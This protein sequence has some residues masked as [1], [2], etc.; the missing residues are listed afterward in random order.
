M[1]DEH[2]TRTG[3][4]AQ[5]G[6]FG[7]PI[8]ILGTSVVTIFDDTVSAE[9]GSADSTGIR[10]KR[11][12]VL[13]DADLTGR[14]H[15]IGVLIEGPQLV[16]DEFLVGVIPN[17]DSTAGLVEDDL[18]STDDSLE[19]SLGGIVGSGRSNSLGG[20]LS[21]SGNTCR[22]EQGGRELI[23]E[24]DS[25]LAVLHILEEGLFVN[26][27]GHRVVN[28]L[29]VANHLLDVVDR[30]GS[31][32]LGGLCG[33]GEPALRVCKRGDV[34]LRD[35][36]AEGDVLNTARVVGV[37]KGDVPDGL[38]LADLIGDRA[39]VG[40]LNLGQ[41]AEE[42]FGEVVLDAVSGRLVHEGGGHLEVL[43]GN[44]FLAVVVLAKLPAGFLTRD[45]AG[46][47][48]EALGS[49]RNRVGVEVYVGSHHLN[50][51]LDLKHLVV[52]VNLRDVPLFETDFIQVLVFATRKNLKVV[53]HEGV[54]RGDAI[55]GHQSVKSKILIHNST[56]LRRLYQEEEP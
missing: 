43:K 42:Q 21:V 17:L 12:D 19:G 22:N 38:H 26:L 15:K 23:A 34:R 10:A 28:L 9:N 7:N 14:T 8:L 25:P 27:D 1:E 3:R 13:L 11:N 4:N 30:V 24:S 20:V 29:G 16:A 40:V 51:I 35:L 2:I 54:R 32:T 18:V 41:T 52:E 55:G 6:E 37:R 39:D 47:G 56:R 44:Q 45:G 46:E 50:L 33:V 5:H 36:G 31:L 48:V 53:C 49:E